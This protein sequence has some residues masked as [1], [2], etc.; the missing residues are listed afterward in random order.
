MMN[1]S[2]ACLR[3]DLLPTCPACTL[4]CVWQGSQLP[5]CSWNHT[6]PHACSAH[7]LP[8]LPHPFPTT[9]PK[10]ASAWKNFYGSHRQHV[11]LILV[12][13][14][15]LL[16]HGTVSDP[17][18][19]PGPFTVSGLLVPPY[20]TAYDSVDI[21]LWAFPEGGLPSSPT[22]PSIVFYSLAS[23][24]TMYFLCMQI[25]YYA[26]LG[27]IISAPDCVVPPPLLVGLHILPFPS[28]TGTHTPLP[29]LYTT[30]PL[31]SPTTHTSPSYFISPFFIVGTL[32]TPHTYLTLVTHTCALLLCP[33]HTH[34]VFTPHHDSAP[35]F[36]TP[37]LLPL[38]HYRFCLLVWVNS[39]PFTWAL[40]PHHT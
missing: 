26:G 10:P 29:S 1:S 17:H 20:E 9:H 2:Q 35:T 36:P 7:F 31:P 37:H 25:M 23:H 18:Y 32:H 21:P 34:R 28:Q 4:Q 40:Q 39:P 11:T 15:L 8:A 6:H 27:P 24:V 19:H 3:K 22:L 14:I 13:P 5:C 16:K 33:R 12:P 38:Q 30:D